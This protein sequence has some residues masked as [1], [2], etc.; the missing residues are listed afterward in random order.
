MRSL[1]GIGKGL[2]AVVV[3]LLLSGVS[4]ADTSNTLL[5]MKALNAAPSVLPLGA[6]VV[7]GD[8]SK[9]EFFILGKADTRDTKP[10][11]MLVTKPTQVVADKSDKQLIKT[12]SKRIHV[13]A[14]K[15]NTSKIKFALNQSAHKVRGKKAALQLRTALKKSKHHIAAKKKRSKVDVALN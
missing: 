1:N 10:V 9:N 8:L 3:T 5:D 13:I 15:K 6:R 7:A 12:A 14:S 11:E 4:Q 2:I